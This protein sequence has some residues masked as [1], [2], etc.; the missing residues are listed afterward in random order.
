MKNP[1]IVENKK[2]YVCKFKTLT[3][4]LS[5]GDLYVSNFI[6]GG[7][8]HKQKKLPLELVLCNKKE[9]GCGLLQL[10]HSVSHELMYRK[11]WYRSGVNKTMRDELHGIVKTIES[12]VDLSSGD[13]VL[14]IGSND[15]TLLR[16][17]SLPD[18]KRIGFE[19]ARNLMSYAREGTTKIFNDFF[20]FPDWKKTLGKTKAKA[21]TAIAMFYDL[22]EPNTFVSHITKCLHENGV[23][24]IQMAY[25]PSM[26]SENA[27]D[28]ICHEHVQYYSLF[29]LEHLLSRH[30]MEVF[31]VILNDINGGSYRTYI[32]HA[33]KGKNIKIPTGAS[34]RVRNLRAFE[35]KL[36]LNERK[37][38][39]DFVKRVMGLRDELTIFVKKEV[40]KGKKIYVYGA[41]TKGNTLLQFYNLTSELIPAAA[42]RNP[43]KWGKHTIGTSI[44]IISEEQARAERPD[45]F[46][47]LPWHFLK[48]FKKREEE[49]LL[50]GGK[51]IVPLPKF[52]VIGKKGR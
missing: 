18:V 21:I 52:K 7:S 31:D 2:C 43:D 26:L 4:I 20:N 5:L 34:K 15:S 50:S 8:N 3:P 48:E 11:Y 45:Y 1:A 42:D 47:V 46:L 32:R 10:K 6:D 23:F 17:Y 38:Y 16:S 13:Y 24:I 35:K 19:P 33:G 12:I 39:D 51:L 29:S 22:E 14:D 37:I 30:N 40:A 25:L 49:F 9:G 27:F 44:P 36:G 28:N 41:S